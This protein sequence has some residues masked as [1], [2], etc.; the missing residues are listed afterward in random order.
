MK[1]STEELNCILEQIDK[2]SFMA[3]MENY[4]YELRFNPFLPKHIHERVFNEPTNSFEDEPNFINFI[5][6]NE[7][8]F[9]I[10]DNLKKSSKKEFEKSLNVL[11]LLYQD[12]ENPKKYLEKTKKLEE[13]QLNT[14]VFGYNYHKKYPVDVIDQNN[15]HVYHK[16]GD[17]IEKLLLFSDGLI[18]NPKLY[19][20]KKDETKIIGCL[21]DLKNA[22]FI[23]QK[24]DNEQETKKTLY[25]LGSNLHIPS[26][27]KEPFNTDLQFD[28]DIL[29]ILQTQIE[30][31]YD[32]DIKIN[33]P[34]L[35]GKTPIH[36]YHR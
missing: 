12:I 9:K 3:F 18:T 14:I 29:T 4:S 25:L 2:K 23:I 22:S 7:S 21:F 24:E 36:L 6:E 15:K 28:K 20:Q 33:Y 17:K 35:E 1:I 5:N 32:Y 31:P 8:F 13:K 30:K 16:K 26:I 19:T 10:L 11:Y 34:P 27:I